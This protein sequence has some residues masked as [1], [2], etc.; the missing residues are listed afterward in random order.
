MTD[1]DDTIR[2]ALQADAGDLP[3][4][5]ERS[6]IAQVAQT[7]RGRNRWMTIGVMLGVTFM[8]VLLIFS[9]VKFFDV[10]TTRDHIMYATLFIYSLL[11]VSMLKLWY[12]MILN[13]NTVTREIKRLEIQI[14]ALVKVLDSE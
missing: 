11:G 8:A 6:I 9:T 1:F 12:W 14:A 10:E 7:M 2:K 13:R 5:D 3:D 4:A